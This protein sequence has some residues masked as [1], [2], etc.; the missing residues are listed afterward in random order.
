V[1]ITGL[2]GTSDM[3]SIEREPFEQVSVVV[4]RQE[5]NVSNIMHIK[6]IIVLKIEYN[7]NTFSE[8]PVPVLKDMGRMFFWNR[9][10]G[11]AQRRSYITWFSAYLF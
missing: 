10:S 11:I 9:R 3:I 4:A 6:Y 5:R 2:K 8:L 1:E 7:K